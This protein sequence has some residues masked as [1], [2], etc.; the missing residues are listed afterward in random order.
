M[1]YNIGPGRVIEFSRMVDAIKA[2]DWPRAADEMLAS[3]W[4]R[5]VGL[6]AMRLAKIMETGSLA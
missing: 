4:A 5:E 3:Q 6:R 2:Q 1:A